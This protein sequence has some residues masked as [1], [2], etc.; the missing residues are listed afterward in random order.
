M[1][2]MY[3]DFKKF[4]SKGSIID[5]SVAVIIGTAFGRVVTSLTRDVIM[6]VISLVVGNQGF[7]NYKYVIK[8]ADEAN[9]IVENAIYYGAFIQNF[10]DFLL[11]AIVIFLIIK[12]V[13]KANDLAQKAQQEM[14][15]LKNDVVQKAPKMEDVLGDIK[16]ILQNNLN[17]K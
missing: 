13:K 10:V 4:I 5:L 3:S 1:K 8:E 15:G 2:K 17:E 16:T 12:F 11:I 9:N 7:E 14:E 6:P